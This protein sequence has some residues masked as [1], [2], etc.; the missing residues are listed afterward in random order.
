M[1][2]SSKVGIGLAALAIGSAL[3]AVLPGARAERE[4]IAARTALATVSP[5]SRHDVDY[6]LLDGR[7]QQ[8]MRRPAMVG[9]AVGVVENGRITFL[10][11][12]G[13]TA[14]DSGEAA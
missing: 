2:T 1:K 13:Q 5:S 7:L 8:L 3:V 14:A 4:R 6:A 10:K 9:L 11:G 12:Y